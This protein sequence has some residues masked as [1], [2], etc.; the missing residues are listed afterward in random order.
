M[1]WCCNYITTTEHIKSPHI[2]WAQ[3][4]GCKYYVTFL[5]WF[6]FHTFCGMLTSCE[7]NNSSM[8][9]K[10]LKK[11][12]DVINFNNLRISPHKSVIST[13]YSVPEHLVY[14]ENIFIPQVFFQYGHVWYA[15][16]FCWKIELVFM[17]SILDNKHQYSTV[18]SFH[19]VENTVLLNLPI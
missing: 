5:Q 17:E 4:T 15:M 1:T 3:I 9:L 12:I 11:H 2:R 7:F 19:S 18:Y 16:K 13:S 10:Y 8:F 14:I 6:H